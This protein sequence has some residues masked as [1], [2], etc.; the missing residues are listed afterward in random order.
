MIRVVRGHR[1]QLDNYFSKSLKDGNRLLLS[2][3]E[4]TTS[5]WEP[6]CYLLNQISEQ[7]GSQQSKTY[8]RKTLH[9]RASRMKI[10]LR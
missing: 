1:R 9:R 3:A 8:W 7:V 6:L 2:K 5:N 4:G 10:E